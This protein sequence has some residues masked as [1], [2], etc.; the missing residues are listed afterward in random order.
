MVIFPFKIK[1]VKQKLDSIHSQVSWSEREEAKL[2]L[3]LDQ[4]LSL[5]EDYCKT[6]SK[7]NWLTEGDLE[8]FRHFHH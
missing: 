4:L 3:E 5:E 6:R 2:E 7:A 1:Q 8:T